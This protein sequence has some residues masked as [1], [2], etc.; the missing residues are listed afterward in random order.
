M[1]TMLRII[2]GVTILCSIAVCVSQLEW[3]RPANKIMVTA[4]VF[5]LV[6]TLI[7]GVGLRFL[8]YL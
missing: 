6:V 2:V 1:D 7:V 4:L 8:P 3:H 5:G